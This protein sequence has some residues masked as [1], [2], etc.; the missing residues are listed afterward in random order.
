MTNTIGIIKEICQPKVTPKGTSIQEIGLE[1]QNKNIIY[2]QAHRNID[3]LNDIEV[4]DEVLVTYETFG[5][6][7]ENQT[8]ATHFTTLVIKKIDKL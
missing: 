2:L 3:I 1:Q 5:K 4:N 7:V 8:G 6:K